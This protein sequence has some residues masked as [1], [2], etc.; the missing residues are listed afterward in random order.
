MG[1]LSPDNEAIRET[2]DYM[3]VLVNSSKRIE[4]LTRAIIVLT[5]VMIVFAV[6]TLLK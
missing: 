6:I 5:G 3:E 4:H 2:R 1:N